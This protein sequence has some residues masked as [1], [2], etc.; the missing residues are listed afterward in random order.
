[1]NRTTA[2]VT[3]ASAA[4]QPVAVSSAA[5]WTRRGPAAAEATGRASVGSGATP[6]VPAHA[7][8]G[9]AAACAQPLDHRTG[10]QSRPPA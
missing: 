2:P 5:R 4:A 10:W 7:V 6:R 3:T 8:T 1:M 9:S